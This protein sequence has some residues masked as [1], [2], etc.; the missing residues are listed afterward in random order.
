MVSTYT[1][2]LV[3]LCMSVFCWRF[4]FLSSI[5]QGFCILW[6]IL[7][8][9]GH[10]IFSLSLSR[11]HVGPTS[12]RVLL[13]LCAVV[14]RLFPPPAKWFYCSSA[15]SVCHLDGFFFSVH[16][17][18]VEFGKTIIF[19]IALYFFLLSSSWLARWPLF[20]SY[21]ITHLNS[22]QRQR[23]IY[24]AFITGCVVFLLATWRQNTSCCLDKTVMII[25]LR[26]QSE[27]V[28]RPAKC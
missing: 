19:N 28:N 27:R 4:S 24:L 25:C 1:A 6:W 15:R 11:K 23:Q 22:K 18:S 3:S 20:S 26:K 16:V 21:W 13:P 7:C 12:W 5:Y 10:E 2:P 14:N 8:N 17:R 9:Y